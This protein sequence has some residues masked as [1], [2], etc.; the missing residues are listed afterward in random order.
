MNYPTEQQSISIPIS[1]KFR[2]TALQF[3]QEQA[4][5]EKAK[6]VY[7]NTLAVQVINNYLQ[8]LDISTT[9][10]ASYS[11][12]YWGRMGADV[13]D[14]LLTG[15]G[16]LECRYIRTG[17]H[18]CHI[19]P[20]VWHHRFGYVVVEINQTCQEAKIIGF[21]PAVTTTEINI[22][23]LQPLE[24]LIEHY[25]QFSGVQLRQWLEGIYTSQWQSIEELA[26]KKAHN[27]P[28]VLQKCGDLR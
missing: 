24:L 8:L 5:P 2:D 12:D 6:Q 13:A 28:F 25:H 22:E 23:Q 11:W 14:L 26:L 10:E 16:H 15:I 18:I 20:E 19:P 9:I 4:N 17:D 1:A 7:L 21:L 27:W 3:A